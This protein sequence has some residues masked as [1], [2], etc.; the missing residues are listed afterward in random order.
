MVRK[1]RLGFTLI[2]LLVVIA[3]IAI[4]IG[5]LLPAVQKVR[6]A[7][8]RMSSSN[9]LHQMAIAAHSYADAKGNLPG[10]YNYNNTYDYSTS[11]AY[12]FH[13]SGGPF[14]F[15]I[16]PYI[17]KGNVYKLG[18]GQRTAGTT[19]YYYKN[20]FSP[21]PSNA[22][23]YGAVINT[24]LNPS[25]ASVSSKGRISSYGAMGYRINYTALSYATDYTYKYATS[26]R[27]YS[28]GTPKALNGIVD[29]T[30]NTIMIGE[31]LAYPQSRTSTS[32]YGHYWYTTSYSYFRKTNMIE[33]PDGI[34]VSSAYNLQARQD[35]TVLVGLMDGSV[36]GI[37][38][39]ISTA[40]WQNAVDDQDG[41]TL[42]SDW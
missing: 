34:K 15:V 10:Y 24:Y 38:A 20:Y 5:L 8:A 31:G 16:L 39:D 3:I 22:S 1:S 41:E 11:G 23:L 2:E 27:Q 6:D 14:A 12:E 36:R 35:G 28:Y 13:Y 4:L 42:G 17:E 40:T 19:K 18:N 37:H 33:I 25:D 29:G 7:A 32:R 26:D 9:N 21:Y 30:S